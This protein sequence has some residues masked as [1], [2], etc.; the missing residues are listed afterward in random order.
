MPNLHDGHRARMRQRLA[1]SGLDHFQPHEVIELLLFYCIPMR[2]VNQLAHELVNRFGSVSGVLHAS[3]EELCSVPGVG[4]ATANWLTRLQPVL[5]E[6]R[7]CR[8]ADRPQLTKSTAALDYIRPLM[9][10]APDQQLWALALSGHGHL[11]GSALLSSGEKMRDIS[12]AKIVDFLLRYRTQLVVIAQRRTPGQMELDQKDIQF[13]RQLE[14]ALQPLRIG[15]MD[16]MLLSGHRELS[17]HK[18]RIIQPR[19]SAGTLN[20]DEGLVLDGEGWDD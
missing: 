13:V 17:L 9:P 10:D 20:E 12:I 14:A 1:S 11:L 6:Y 18:M 3:K 15:L 5:D 2:N 7:A 4:E 19:A 16:M 8:M